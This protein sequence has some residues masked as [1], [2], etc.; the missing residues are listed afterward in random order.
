MTYDIRLLVVED[1]AEELDHWSRTI[2][3]HNAAEKGSIRLLFARS[4]ADARELL[5]TTDISAAVVDLRLAG[6]NDPENNSGND[7]LRDILSKN[8]TVAAIFTGQPTDANIPEFAR[9]QAKVFVKGGG[10]GEVMAWIESMI[11][12]MRS[13]QKAKRTI[14]QEMAHIF[15]YAIWPR[16]KYWVED[17]AAKEQ[18]FLDLSLARHI[19]SHVHESLSEKLGA[20]A[21]AEEWFLLPSVQTGLKTGDL[22]RR[23]DGV[24]EVVV[25]PRCDFAS[26]KNTTVQLAECEDI[27][28]AWDEIEKSILKL[29][30]EISEQGKGGSEEQKKLLGSLRSKQS[31]AVNHDNRKTSKHFL[32]RMKNLDGSTLGPFFVRFDRIRSPDKESKDSSISDR[33]RRLTTLSPVFLPSMVERLGAFFSRIGTPDY[34]HPDEG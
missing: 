4:A 17:P 12:L 11:P 33:A 13:V 29:R 1:S 28:K 10:H 27:S 23:E 15:N 14:S 19:A 6:N 24:V 34:S 18:D 21:H 3:R 16:W 32:P 26:A 30:A 25:T 2:E 31:N 8:Q 7:V 9:E 5:D 20:K 22:I